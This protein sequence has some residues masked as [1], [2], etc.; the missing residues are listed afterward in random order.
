M[1]VLRLNI[2]GIQNAKKEP[3]GSF[4]FSGFCAGG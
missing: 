4:F 1:S 3:S 2:T